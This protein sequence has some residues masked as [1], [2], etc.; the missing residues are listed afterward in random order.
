MCDRHV[1]CSNASFL[2]DQLFCFRT[3]THSPYNLCKHVPVILLLKSV[4]YWSQI[5]TNTYYMLFRFSNSESVLWVI[6]DV[7]TEYDIVTNM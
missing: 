2:I 5:T 4:Y 6:W 3:I 1:F 7:D